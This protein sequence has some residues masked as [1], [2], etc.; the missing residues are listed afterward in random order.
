[1]PGPQIIVGRPKK[2]WGS[3]GMLPG[4]RI[5]DVNGRRVKTPEE[6]EATFKIVWVRLSSSLFSYIKLQEFATLLIER[7]RRPVE[8][9]RQN[10]HI[11]E[12][13]WCYPDFRKPSV[14]AAM[15]CLPRE[16]QLPYPDGIPE[17][18]RRS[19]GRAGHPRG[20]SSPL[21]PRPR[22]A[23]REARAHRHGRRPQVAAREALQ[24]RASSFVL[25]LVSS[26]RRRVRTTRSSCTPS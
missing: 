18:E 2:A 25:L 4:D 11:A 23:P 17:D 26:C 3:L 13:G 7:P 16:S 21:L 15:V 10:P 20:G 5:I 6:V 12:S 22:H 19:H 8:A 14:T 1:M 9:V 24:A